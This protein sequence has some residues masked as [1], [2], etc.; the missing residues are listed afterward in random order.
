MEIS[1]IPV[2]LEASALATTI[3]NSLYLFP[4]IESLHV[5]GITAVVG[6]VLIIDLRLLGLA[7]VNRSFTA[8]AADVFRWT[9]LAF[10][11]AAVSGGLMFVT[12][13][14]SYYGNVYFRL[15]MA[16]LVLAG[17]NMLAFELTARR[18]VAAWN[19]WPAATPAGKRVAVASL[20]IWVVVIFLGRW[21]GFTLS[22]AT[23]TVDDGVDLEELE[24]LIPK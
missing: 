12:N 19:S 20:A 22:T 10:V 16:M 7:S 18:S 17:A 1:A 21:V 9:W 6:T 23:P 8:I 15:K 2:W 5:V 11:L 4:L 3:R 13:A 24:N 14:T